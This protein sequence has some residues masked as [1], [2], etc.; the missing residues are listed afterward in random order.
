MAKEFPRARRV[1]EQVQRAKSRLGE[2]DAN[3]VQVRMELQADCYAGVWAAQNRSLIEPGDI[4]E[5]MRAAYAVG[6]DTLM[7]G[8][9]RAPVV[10]VIVP[11]DTG[12]TGTNTEIGTGS[13]VFVHSNVPSTQ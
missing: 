6:D 12:V 13:P 11:F 7:R 10:V 3:R 4:E 2:R 8:T 5:G 1:A 9:G